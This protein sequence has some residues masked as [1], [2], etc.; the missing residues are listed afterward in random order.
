MDMPQSR[1]VE[2]PKFLSESPFGKT[3]AYRLLGE[4]KLRAKRLGNRTIWDAAARDEYLA[5]LPDVS[6]AA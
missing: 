3:Q 1:W 2:T 5:S 4:G 6:K